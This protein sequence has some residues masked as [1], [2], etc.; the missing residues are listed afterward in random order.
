V[1]DRWHPTLMLIESYIGPGEPLNYARFWFDEPWTGHK[2]KSAFLTIGLDDLYTPA[3]LNFALVT[4]ARVPVVDPAYAPIEGN[5]I[6]GL[7]PSFP[8]YRGNVANGQASAGLAQ[9]EGQGHFVI[10]D[11]PSAQQRAVN[12][13]LSM[14]ED[15]IPQ[16]F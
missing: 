7:E 13:V 3:E 2:P 15:R 12:F 11:I 14:A 5:E 10:F 6:L 4:A 16:I 1:L 8:P 9:Y